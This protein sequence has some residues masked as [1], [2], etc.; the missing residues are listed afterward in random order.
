[1]AAPLLPEAIRLA[2]RHDRTVYDCLYLAL[3]MAHD[4]LL[5]TADAHFVNALAASPLADRVRAHIE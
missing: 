5:I 1:M 2:L 4:C 3:A